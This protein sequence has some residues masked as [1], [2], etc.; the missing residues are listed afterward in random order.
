MQ[1]KER[2]RRVCEAKRLA[3]ST[4][5]TD[6]LTAGHIRKLKPE[7]KSQRE[8]GS[9]RIR[10]IGEELEG[11]EASRTVRP[12]CETRQSSCCSLVC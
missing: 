10:T 1:L 9:S 4:K 6:Q 3:D 5:S 8:R 7:R 2:S 11:E 12:P